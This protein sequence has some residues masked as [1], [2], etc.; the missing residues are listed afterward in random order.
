MNKKIYIKASSSRNDCDKIRDYLL[1]LGGKQAYHTYTDEP[2]LIEN[3]DYYYYIN[4]DNEILG[5]YNRDRL[6]NISYTELTIEE[7]DN[8]LNN[9]NSTN[10]SELE[11]FKLI[12]KRIKN[13]QKSLF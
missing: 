5:S 2:I 11:M 12:D 8:I 1:S 7:L 9:P 13:G 10:S 6:S 4:E 3:D